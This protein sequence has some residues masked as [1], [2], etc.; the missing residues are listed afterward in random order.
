MTLED[1]SAVS[2]WVE[3]TDLVPNNWR[4]QLINSFFDADAKEK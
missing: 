2:S 3:Y 1:G 4:P